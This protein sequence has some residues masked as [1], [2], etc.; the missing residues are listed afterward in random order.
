MDAWDEEGADRA[1]AALARTAGAGEVLEVFLRYGARD[2]RDIGHKAI[3]VANAWRTL[4]TIGWRHAEPVLRSLAYA[5]LEHGTQGNPAT[6]DYAADRPGRD[7]LKR[8]AGLSSLNRNTKDVPEATTELLETLRTASASEASAKVNQLLQS[9]VK[10]ER[11]W[12]ALF[13]TAGELLM[14]QPGIVGLHCVTSVNALYYGFQASAND[15]TRKF[16]MLQTAAFLALF[17]EAMRSRGNGVLADVR[18]TALQK[19]Q[20]RLEGEQAIEDIFNT[21]SKDRTAAAQKTLAFLAGRPDGA[22]A[23]MDAARRLIFTKGRDSHDYKFSSA[24]LEDYYHVSPAWRG[25][26]LATSMFNL[27]GTGD[28]DNDLIRRTRAALATG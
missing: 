15:D 18:V 25:H 9:E 14:R 2:F 26:F 7:N 17:R 13:L 24:A 23:L 8:L 6:N 5:V 3:Y 20:S 10:P 27:K 4:H 21:V 28:R 16:L 12:D 1:V 11:I 19:P 22:T